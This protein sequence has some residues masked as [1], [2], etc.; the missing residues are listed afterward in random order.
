M[1]L[2][3]LLEQGRA[4]VTGNTWRKDDLIH[5]LA[6]KVGEDGQ[7]ARLPVHADADL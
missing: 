5:E 6:A 4:I 2:G 1:C 7:P 3:R